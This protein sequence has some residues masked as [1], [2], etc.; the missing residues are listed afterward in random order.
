LIIS[1]LSLFTDTKTPSRPTEWHH[2]SS[3][4]Y[5]FYHIWNKLSPILLAG[6]FPLFKV[7]SNYHLYYDNIMNPT[8]IWALYLKYQSSVF[9]LASCI[10]S[11]MEPTWITYKDTSLLYDLKCAAN[12]YSAY[13]QIINSIIKTVINST[14]ILVFNAINILIL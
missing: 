6:I 5:I 4:F 14:L 13:W 7:H 3:L 10:K 12:I 1:R 2:V 8:K 11:F 9:E